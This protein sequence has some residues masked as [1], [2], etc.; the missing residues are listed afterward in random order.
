MA[1]VEWHQGLEIGLGYD[2]VRGEAKSRAVSGEM[3]P[4]TGAG[5]QGGHSSFLLVESEDE[6][7]KA[8]K[9]DVE[10]G[11]GF[12]LFSAQG[13]FD[14]KEQCKVSTQAKF[15]VISVYAEDPYK[16][17]A[18]P[19]LTADAN[20][21]LANGN[22]KRFR[23]RFGDLFVSGEQTGVEFYGVARVEGRTEER[24]LEIAAE[25]QAQ[26]GMVAGGSASVDTKTKSL[27][28]EE[29]VEILTY[30][31]GGSIQ[32]AADVDQLVALAQRALDEG[33]GGQSYRFAV[34]LDPYTE[35]KL[36]NDDASF[37]KIEAARHTLARLG[38]HRQAFL[39]LQNDIDFVLT[40]QAWY[41][42]DAAAITA[43]NEANKAIDDELNTITERADTCSTDF[44]ACTE[45]SPTYPSVTIPPR[46]DGTP[47]THHMSP[48]EEEMRKKLLEEVR[49]PFIRGTDRA[50][51]LKEAGDSA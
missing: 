18:D 3:A 25:I 17:L 19:V 46:T 13:K 34:G 1:L 51:F 11:G 26:Y 2:D 16:Q 15:C 32:A 24:S 12:G 41:E 30:Q 10:A 27:H 42:V 7:D 28:K 47:E 22:Q 21:L 38:R 44:D 39:T 6:F 23:E 4:T 45:Y 35:L 20:E 36:P 8:I 14:F 33:R 29:R 37:V 49:V 40:H 31:Q 9:F 48:E 5:G 50:R 43:L